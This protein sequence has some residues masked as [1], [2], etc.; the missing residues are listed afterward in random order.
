VKKK[1]GSFR[2]YLF[3]LI[4]IFT[5]SFFYWVTDHN[6]A[7]VFGMILV[8]LVC[9]L[10]YLIECRKTAEKEQLKPESIIYMCAGAIFD[11]LI[12]AFP[13]GFLR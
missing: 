9:Y 1:K 6:Y 7:H 10:I 4:G 8:A 13:F 2:N 3:F 5:Y 12:S 11:S